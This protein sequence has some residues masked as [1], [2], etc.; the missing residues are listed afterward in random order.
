MVILIALGTVV[1]AINMSLLWRE[2]NSTPP[3]QSLE[4][5]SSYDELRKYLAAICT[6]ESYERIFKP[7]MRATLRATE[8]VEAFSPQPSSMIVKGLYYSETNVQVAGVD[9]ADI[10]KTDGAYIYLAMDDKVYIVRAY[11]PSE[12]GLIHVLRINN[13]VHG[14]YL[15]KDYLVVICS[16]MLMRCIKP[17][18]VNTTLMVFSVSNRSRPRAL[19]HLS[20]SGHYLTSRRLDKFLY[21][22]LQCPIKRGREIIVPRINSTMIKPSD[23]LCSKETLPH[24]YVVIVAVDI[25]NGRHSEKALLI[26][27]SDWVYM[28]KNSL[29]IISTRYTRPIV[30]TIID[31]ALRKAL[32]LFKGPFR[33]R[34]KTISY[35]SAPYGKLT[36][37]M[38][39]VLSHPFHYPFT[40]ESL[41][42]ML[43]ET[44]R[45]FLDRKPVEES[46]IYKFKLEGLEMRQIAEAVVKG[47]VF[48]QFSMDEYKRYFRIATTCTIIDIVG[49]AVERKSAN[50]IYVFNENLNLIGKLEGLAPGE[51]IYAA[52]YLGDIAL[53]VTFRR[54]DPLFGIDLSDPMNPKVVGFLKVLGYSEYLHPY[55]DNL[56][57]GIGMAADEKGRFHGLKVSLFDIDDLSNIVE[58]SRLKIDGCVWS[59][60]FREHHA[61]TIND[62][63]S[64]FMFP[65][66]IFCRSELM[67]GLLV[68]S[69][70]G[71]RLEQKGIIRHDCLRG[72]YIGDFIYSIGHSSIIIVDDSTLEVVGV[73]DLTKG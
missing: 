37:A 52:R 28:S 1:L 58:V 42:G 29:Y 68:V 25:T 26:G 23:I 27:S 48:D 47:R 57:I 60:A 12:A 21:L 5:F 62:K 69:I 61:F 8:T 15:Y 4:A 44:T 45:A 51:R 30:E 40:R 53:L 72:I 39:I 22:L 10:V 3:K 70:R 63:K 17:S 18:V 24:N 65:I 67:R 64:Y 41:V 9:E 31:K 14:V 36:R 43:L 11:P 19:F 35:D 59:E 6:R 56:L 20:M 16:S 34:L 71:D 54:V 55:G 33:L 46:I 38:N 32:Y 73:V 2:S 13:I 50:N 7:P 49:N 66:R